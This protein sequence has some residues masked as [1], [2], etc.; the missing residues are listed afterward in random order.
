[1]TARESVEGM[2][3]GRRKG[4]GK[5]SNVCNMSLTAGDRQRTGK[6]VST[7]V[8]VRGEDKAQEKEIKRRMGVGAPG[9]K[10]S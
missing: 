9:C 7:S 5:R 10:G 3:R 6:T 8:R 1:M 4:G 2:V